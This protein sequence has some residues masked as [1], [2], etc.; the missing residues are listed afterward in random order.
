MKF[1]Q[2]LA[3][4]AIVSLA[5][6]QK[7]YANQ[8]KERFVYGKPGDQDYGVPRTAQQVMQLEE[9]WTMDLGVQK[10]RGVLQ[11]FHRGLYKS[12]D[13]EIP[14]QCIS[15]ETVKKLWYV[16][17]IVSGFQFE[18]ILALVSLFYQLYFNFDFECNLEGTLWDLS[19]F[20]FDHDCGWE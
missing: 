8:E 18:E 1:I 19:N 6:G 5:A 11:G 9:M 15:R 14:D 10:F 2:T 3:I 12:Y 13:W 4:G 17:R 7:T 16:D 20:C